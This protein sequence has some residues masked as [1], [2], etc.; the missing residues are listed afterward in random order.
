M[1]LVIDIILPELLRHRLTNDVDDYDDDDVDH[2][3]RHKARDI[4]RVG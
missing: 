1:L 3:L 4:R 2:P